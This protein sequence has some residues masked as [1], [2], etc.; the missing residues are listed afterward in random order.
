MK[1]RP[2]HHARFAALLLAVL[3]FIP[4]TAS[5]QTPE[6]IQ[7][8]IDENNA[9]IEALNKEIAAYEKQLGD[10]SAKKKTLQSTV[11]QLNVSIK[12]TTASINV[13]KS[14]I[15]STQ[16]QIQ[17]LSEGI[18]QKE[19]SIGSVQAGIA[20]SIRR[21]NDFENQPLAALILSKDSFSSMWEDIDQSQALQAALGDQADEL[22]A[23]KQTLS[24]TKTNAE[25][26]RAQLLK[27]QQTLQSQQGSLNAQKK[28]QSDL[29]TQTKQQESSYQA[30][31]AQKQAEMTAFQRA[32]FDLAS[33]LEYTLDPSRIPSAGKGV[34]R[35]P[36][37]NVYITQ[38]FGKT[39]SAKRLY[40]SGTHDGVDFRASIGTPVKATLSG[41]VVEI[42]EGAVRN[43]QYGKWVLIR[44]GNGLTTLY[45]HL[46][47]IAVAKG[48]SVATGQVIGYSGDTGY[49]TG[50]HLHL[51]VYASEAVNFK[52][53]TCKSG[54]STLIP[55]AN[56]SAYLNPLDYL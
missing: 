51:T 40:T 6:E 24:D 4:L 34:L 50:P 19:V 3:V 1:T 8:K 39:A 10:I 47:D 11:D 15:N 2:S 33:Q 25:E 49:A 41:T 20:E 43:C 42:N 54:K 52:T 14:Q 17:Q 48:A 5:S 13:T 18:A 35:W 55:I 21:L 16:L 38:Q 45:A 12:K 30:I 53:Y 27:Q 9:Q 7:R 22:S 32:L 28:S 31:L 56:P 26:K 29:L 23:Q 44:H 46:S 36:L 37:A